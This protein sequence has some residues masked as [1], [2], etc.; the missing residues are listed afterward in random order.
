V[1][2]DELLRRLVVPG[3]PALDYAKEI[4]RQAFKR[5]F[6]AA[7]RTLPDRE[8]T[9]LRQH[10]LDGLSIDKLASLYRVHRATAARLLVRARVRVLEATRAQMMSQ[11]DVRSQDLDSILRL[12]RSQIEI[13]LHDLQRR[14][15][16]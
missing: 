3:D 16:R 10:Y 13:S 2:D 4:Y 1:E 6:E 5:A 7:L 8:R 12:I 11:L 14:A 9:L 15:K